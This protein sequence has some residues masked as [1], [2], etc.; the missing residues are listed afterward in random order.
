MVLCLEGAEHIKKDTADIFVQNLVNSGN[1]IL[2]S[3]AIPNQGGQNHFNE[4]WFTYWEEK[5]IVH[6]YILHD[7]I[8]P[9]FWDNSEL[10]FGTNKI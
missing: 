1:L 8:R 7:I 2:F 5:F 6:N 9:F 4:Q 10:F 3:A